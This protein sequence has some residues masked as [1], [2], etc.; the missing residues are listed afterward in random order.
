MKESKEW[1]P[2]ENAKIDYKP[3]ELGDKSYFM[4]ASVI[5]SDLVP[6][7]KE[8]KGATRQYN[9]KVTYDLENKS[10]YMLDFYQFS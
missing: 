3:E 8:E 9:L 5:R 10:R 7:G 4:V 6:K 1:V 2:K